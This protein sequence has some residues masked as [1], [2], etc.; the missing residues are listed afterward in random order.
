MLQ[1]LKTLTL[2]LAMVV[3]L[4]FS[5][6]FAP[7][8]PMT[9]YVLFLML[10]V[11]FCRISL[12]DVHFSPMMLWLLLIQ[13]LGGIAVYLLIAPVDQTVAQ[14]VAI[15]VLAPTA[16]SSA[17]VAAMLGANVAVMASFTLLS[18][19]TVAICAPVLFSFVGSHAGMPFW[20]SF[21]IV[22]S[23]VGPLIIVPMALAFLLKKLAPAVHAFFHDRQIISF[24]MWAF[25]L[26]IV[27]A[28]TVEFIMEQDEG[29][30]HTEILIGAGSFI[31]CIGQFMIGRLIGKRHGERIAGGQALGQK[32]TLLAIWMAQ[33]YMNPLASIGPAAY[34]LWQNIVNS[35]QLWRCRRS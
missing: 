20:E 5:D 34:V 26:I 2:P 7:L 11:T 13:I 1:H 19:V 22:I 15:C 12:A 29:C 24:Y 30:Y 31:A 35:W 9:P 21:A 25:T 27:T 14:G 8:S 3:G 28:R 10:F 33:T 4:V 18:N 16:V 23:R 6:I 17:V 32:N